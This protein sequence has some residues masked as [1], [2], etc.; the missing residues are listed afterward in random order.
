MNVNFIKITHTHTHTDIY[1][2]IYIVFELLHKN[3]KKI[4]TAEE[5]KEINVDLW[6]FVRFGF[7][8]HLFYKNSIIMMIKG[9]Y[10]LINIVTS[11]SSIVM[12]NISS[13]VSTP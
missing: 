11:F 2:Y 10:M 13:H 4:Q 6:T 12:D 1:I 3:Y 5:K 7:S 8:R 9:L